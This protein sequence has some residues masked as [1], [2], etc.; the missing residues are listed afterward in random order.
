MWFRG[1]HVG[2]IFVNVIEG[3]PLVLNVRGIWNKILCWANCA[4]ILKP[5]H[6]IFRTHDLQPTAEHT[7]FSYSSR[8]SSNLI[9]SHSSNNNICFRSWST[10]NTPQIIG[11]GRGA[12]VICFKQMAPQ[13]RNDFLNVFLV[14]FYPI[15]LMISQLVV[16]F[17]VDLRTSLKIINNLV[18]LSARHV[19]EDHLDVVWITEIAYFLH[20]GVRLFGDVETTLNNLLRQRSERA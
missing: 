17:L 18:V 10:G 19:S 7:F 11:F 2:F 1:T 14:F 16:K 12:P 9:P 3:Q 15:T 8:Y 4:S 20:V 5:V 6:C 13:A